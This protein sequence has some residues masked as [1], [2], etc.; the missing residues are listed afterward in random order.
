VGESGVI[1]GTHD[2]GR[3]WYVVQPAVTSAS[4]RAVQRRSA[5]FALA[6]GGQGANPFTAA[7]PDS[8]Q[9]QLANVGAA[10]D[11]RGLR[12]VDDL[13]G[14]GVGSNGQGIVLKTE[15]GG[16]V[17]S[18]QISSSVEPLRDVWFVDSLR[19]WAVGAAGRIV[20]TAKGG[21]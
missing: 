13:T 14:Y 9:W 3:S 10:N 15:N 11:M 17:W 5:T 12:M 18:L 20:H 4:L 7:T 6:L 2:G 8:L 19:G 16:A 21:L 1:V